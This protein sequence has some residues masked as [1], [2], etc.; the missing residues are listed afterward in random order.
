VQITSASGQHNIQSGQPLPD[1][2]T[3]LLTA[4]PYTYSVTAAADVIPHGGK[5]DEAAVRREA[6]NFYFLDSGKISPRWNINYGLRYEINSRIKE[7]KDRT[8]IAIP[9]DTTGQPVSFTTPG[10]QQIYRYNP[11][12]VYPTDW[13]RLGTA[14]GR[15]FCGQ[16]THHL[17]RRRRDHHAFAQSLARQLRDRRLPTRL[18]APGHRSP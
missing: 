17:A 13:G 5:F 18:P 1:A 3:G 6:Y 8:S 11:Q 7:A 10:A 9:V 15:R 4:T 12:P 2:L 14:R 16:Q